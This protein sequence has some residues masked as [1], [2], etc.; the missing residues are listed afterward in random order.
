MVAVVENDVTL[1]D[2]IDGVRILEDGLR[3]GLISLSLPP[4]PGCK[5]DARNQA[6]IVHVNRR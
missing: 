1:E 2:E 6:P 4:T 5:P 3:N